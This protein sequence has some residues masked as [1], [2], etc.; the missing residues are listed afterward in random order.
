MGQ[1]EISAQ[2]LNVLE[3]LE[4]NATVETQVAHLAEGEL[5]RRLARYQ[6]SNRL[7]RDKYG[8]SLVEFEERNMVKHFDYSF[9]VES[10]HQDWDLAIEGIQ[11]IERQLAQLRGAG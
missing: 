5:R 2:V 3:A 10:D 1:I 8:M 6:L 9:E 11:T 7:F 4:P